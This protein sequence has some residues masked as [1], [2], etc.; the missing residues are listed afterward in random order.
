MRNLFSSVFP[1]V[2]AA[3]L[4]S[5]CAGPEQKIGRGVSNMLEI[6]RLGE[7][8][9]SYEQTSVMENRDLGYTTGFIRGI[10]LTATR[11]AV[12]V[13]EVA[14]FPFP[15]HSPMNY[16]PICTTVIPE[17]PV[18]PD[19]YRPNWL[20]DHMTSPDNSLGYG[21]GDVAPFIPGSRFHVFDQ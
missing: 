12:G 19:S 15:N 14:T 1:F 2:G 18:N 6:T 11:T 21:G 3:L 9:R 13:Y 10:D 16:G 20:A 17:N 5:G 4:I 7:L 8:R